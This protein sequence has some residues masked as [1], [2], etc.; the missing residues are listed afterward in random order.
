MYDAPRRPAAPARTARHRPACRVPPPGARRPPSAPSRPS[1]SRR[2]APR[3]CAGSWSR[4]SR[5]AGSRSPSWAPDPVSRR[6]RPTASSMQAVVFGNG[7]SASRSA[8][9]SARSISTTC[10]CA[11]SGARCSLSTPSPPP[12][13]STTS[14]GAELGGALDHAEDVRVDQEVLAE[15]ALRPDGEAAQAAQ[16]GLNGLAHH[17]KRR[18]SVGVDERP[19]APRRTVRARSATNCAVCTT[20]A[21]RLRSLRTRLRGQVRARRSRPAAARRARARPPW[22]GLRPSGT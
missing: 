11:T 17:P 9:S 7:S 21:G 18:C 13:S 6:S 1:A 19:R 16:T 15:V 10:R 8:G 2:R 20:N 22:P 14:S 12:T 3:S 5:R 4:R